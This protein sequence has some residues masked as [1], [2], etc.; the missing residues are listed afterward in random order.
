MKT[1]PIEASWRIVCVVVFAAFAGGGA[2]GQEAQKILE[3]AGVKGGLVVHIGCGDGRLTAQLRGNDSFL[4]HGLDRAAAN[5]K[6]A[7]DH[8]KSAGLYGPVSVDILRGSLLPY[9]DNSVNLVVCEGR[10]DVAMDEVMR[11]LAPGGAACIKDNGKWS[12]RPKRRP[13][14]IDEWTHYLH[15]ASNNAV[16]HDTAIGPVRH[17]QW[18]ASPRYS[19]HHEF[20]SSVASVVSAR[21]RLFS[22]I[23]MGSRASIYMPAKWRLMARDA[24]NGVLLWER[25]IESW[26]NHLW[27]LKDGPAQPPRRLVAVAESVYVTLGFEAPVSRLDAAT[28]KTLHTYQGTEFTEEILYS[29]GTLFLLKNNKSMNPKDYYPKLMVCW[30]EKNRTMKESEG[31]LLGPED[32]RIMAVWAAT[33]QVLWEAEYPVEPLTLAADAEGVYFHDWTSIVRLDRKT[34]KEVWRSEPI[35]PRKNMGYVYGPTLVAYDDVI[36]FTDGRLKRKIYAL[37]KK[38]GRLL[39]EAP[40]YPGGHAGSAEDLLV[41]DGLVWCGKIAGGRDSGVFTGRDPRTGQVRREFTPDVQTYWFHHRCYRAKATDRYFLASRTGIE[42][43]DLRKQSWQVHHWVRGACTYGVLPCNGLIYA[44]PHPCACYLDAKLAGFCALA[45]SSQRKLKFSDTDADRLLKGPAYGQKAKPADSGAGQWPTYRHDAARSGATRAAVGLPLSRQWEVKAGEALTSPVVADG[46]VLVGSQANHA[47]CAL[48]AD[49]G[50]RRWSFTAGARLDSPPTVY[51]GLVIFG[52]ADGYVYCLRA[53]DAALVWRFRAAPMDV[54]LVSYGRLESVWPVSGSVLVENGQVYC[55]AGRSAYLDS[56]LR[57]CRLD[58][59]TGK[60][61]SEN[62]IYDQQ[63]PQRDVKVLNMPTALPDILSS[64]GELLYMRL[65]A[66]DMQCR[67]VR[68]VD[69]ELD[70]VEKA[71]SQ[72]G[73]G[74]H[75]FSPTGFLDDNAWHRSYWVYGRA[76]SSGCNWWFRAGRYAPAGRMLVFDAERVYGFG[77]ESGLFVWSPV[78]EYRLFCSAKQA[79]AEAIARVKQWSS[80]GGRAAVF[81][82]QFTRRAAPQS[83]Y[84]PKVYWSVEHPPI[85]ARAMVLAGDALFVAGPPDVLSEDEAFDAPFD[86]KTV[87]KI[88]E[89]DAA[90]RGARGALL[91]VV[92]AADGR[93]LAEYKLKSPPVWDGMAAAAG[94]LYVAT[95]DGRVLCMGSK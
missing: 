45:P 46:L 5:V 27:P 66:F 69:P 39:W 62:V 37:A 55:V 26:F 11:V 52:S 92:A 65:Q 53:S 8:I 77:R 73:E 38:D 58:A 33:G 21:G 36:L 20:T 23:D 19:R 42:F 82:R 60:L 63:N 12:V 29:D 35:V 31:W 67:R 6:A 24:F 40:H 78:F 68:T 13:D 71:A 90:Y 74:V 89:Q 51:G 2:R 3:L 41:A 16:A 79:D 18:E 34:G 22:I 49:T 88:A 47:L 70:P 93:K 10:P 30:D 91:Q 32:R 17:L 44:P 85:H 50:Q 76:F 14:T 81:D 84:A 72:L 94:R 80:K 1:V 54:R 43:V 28:G 4:V 75:L 7:R 64:D 57:L 15:D 61:L 48:D 56:G 87:A 86:A 95:M 83:R 59:E 25:P 9:V